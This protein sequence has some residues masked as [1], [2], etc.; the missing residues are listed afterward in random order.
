MRRRQPSARK[1]MIWYL[2]ILA[3]AI[4]TLSVV[5]YPVYVGTGGNTYME[6]FAIDSTLSLAMGARTSDTT[7]L[8]TIAPNT[9]IVLFW[10]SNAAT[11]SWQ[12]SL[13]VTGDTMKDI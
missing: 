2:A 3:F 10:N 4:P 1:V 7:L 5:T 8:S 9:Q 13:G 6:L 12:Y 11:W